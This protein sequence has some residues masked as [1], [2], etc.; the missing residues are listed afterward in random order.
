MSTHELSPAQQQKSSAILEAA[1]QHFAK[2]GF[3]AT[4]LSD[5]AQDAGVAVGTIYLRYEGKAELLQGVLDNVETAFCEAMDTAAIWETTFPERFEMIIVAMF[6]TADQQ[7]HFAELMALSGFSAKP[8]NM[9]KSPILSKIEAHIH[10]G[11]ARGELRNDIDPPLAA[12]MAHGMVD[13]AMRELMTNKMQDP[14]VTISHITDAY[15]RWL[16]K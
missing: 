7:T 12:R 3:E 11:I 6:E 1:R 10:D 5:V 2:H 4:K 14:V 9:Q 8:T 16:I 13:G 15:A